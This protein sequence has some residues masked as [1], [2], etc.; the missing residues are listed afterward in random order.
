MECTR[1]PS[2]PYMVIASRWDI[3]QRGRKHRASLRLL[4]GKQQ[5]MTGPE[6]EAKRLE[7]K[8]RKGQSGGRSS[9]SSSDD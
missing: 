2:A 5:A 3:H 9:S 1:D 8:Q 4:R 6:V 7:R